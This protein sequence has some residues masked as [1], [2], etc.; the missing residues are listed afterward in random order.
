[1][2]TMSTPT[3]TPTPTDS[4]QTYKW[5]SPCGRE[6]NFV[7]ADDTPIVFR[8]L[9]PN[10]SLTPHE[11]ARPTPE[12]SF[13]EH[14]LDAVEA[15]NGGEAKLLFAGTLWKKFDPTRITTSASSQRVYFRDDD[16]GLCLLHPHLAHYMSERFVPT[17]K[18]ESG[19]AFRWLGDLHEMRVAP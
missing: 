14:K 7:R 12:T 8:D 17:T 6:L 4:K 18:F 15:E 2:S 10:S 11:Q 19:W 1:M 9:V 3:P 13:N 16:V 5:A